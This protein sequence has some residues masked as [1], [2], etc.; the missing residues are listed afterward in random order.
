MF[1]LDGLLDLRARARHAVH[2]IMA[3]WVDDPG[4]T[5]LPARKEKVD[6]E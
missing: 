1:L 4:E 2:S 3:S 6:R 5:P